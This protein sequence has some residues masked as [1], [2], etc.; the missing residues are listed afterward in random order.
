MIRISKSLHLFASLS[1][2][3]TQRIRMIDIFI[4][5]ARN[6]KDDRR[7][8]GFPGPISLSFVL[9]YAAGDT[10]GWSVA[11]GSFPRD[12]SSL[13]KIFDV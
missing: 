2:H 10:D 9:N 5:F 13:G 12:K 4:S 11:H 6:C 3:E 1:F 7:I 8:G